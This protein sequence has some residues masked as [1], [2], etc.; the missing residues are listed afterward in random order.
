M[1][2][3]DADDESQKNGEGCDGSNN[4]SNNKGTKIRV[5]S[6]FGYS[7]QS[8]LSVEMVEDRIYLY[9][10]NYPEK[11]GIEINNVTQIKFS[12]SNLILHFEKQLF[13]LEMSFDDMIT[14]ES[15]FKCLQSLKNEAFEMIK[16][17]KVT[18]LSMNDQL[19]SQMKYSTAL[20]YSIFQIV[21]NKEIGY[22]LCSSLSVK[23]G[24]ISVYRLLHQK[25]NK[26]LSY[27]FTKWGMNI[28]EINSLKM[29]QDK[30]R[31]RIH[32]MANQNMDLQA[33]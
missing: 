25:L 23:E 20:R 18:K 13:E 28:K 12:D 31:W 30:Y 27:A 8:L 11:L 19:L 10:R 33:W 9:W 6:K 2:D 1:S 32:A 3:F 17:N 29:N 15:M 4:D 16:K 22:Q 24:S 5:H 14:C 7:Y 26:I 21:V